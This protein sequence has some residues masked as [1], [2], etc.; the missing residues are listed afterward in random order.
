MGTLAYS[1]AFTLHFRGVM[2]LLYMLPIEKTIGNALTHW[3]LRLGMNR[4]GYY[5]AM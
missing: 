2:S 5:F 3:L 1:V 4:D